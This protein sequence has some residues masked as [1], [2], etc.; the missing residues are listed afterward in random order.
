VK[1]RGG[2]DVLLH[3]DGLRL[4]ELD[5]VALGRA[6]AAALGRHEVTVSY[7]PIVDLVTGRPHTLEALARW[8]PGGRAVPPEVIVRVAEACTLIDPLFEFVLEDAC[9][10]LARWTTLPGGA[11]LRV[12]VNITPAQLASHELPLVVADHLARHG[13][14]GEQLCLEITE[15]Q[16]LADT[17]TSRAVC[18]E[19][20]ALG[21]GLAL[22][23]FGTG[24]STLSRLRDLPIDEV[25]IDRSFVGNLD[26][27]EARRRFVWGVVAFAERIGFTVV[28]EGVEREA[29]L[30]ALSKL[31]CHRAQGYLF[32]RPVPGGDVD[33]L[34]GSPHRWLLVAPE[35]PREPTGGTVRQQAREA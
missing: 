30:E 23:D 8:S 1:Q 19:L 21:V 2:A 22:D 34:L 18:T 35:A 29:E 28:A 7:Q 20:R 27:D 5:D 11:G 26:R 33:A 6:L 17:E 13:L 10:E 14:T 12:A 15:T 24:Q 3:T 25:K 16:R 32:S 4:A 9:A 31:G